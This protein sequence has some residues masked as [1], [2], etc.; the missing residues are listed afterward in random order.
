MNDISD[1]PSTDQVIAPE[2]IGVMLWG[3]SPT[4]YAVVKVHVSLVR[5][6]AVDNRANS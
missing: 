1:T 5:L 4:R 3:A 6:R 2:N